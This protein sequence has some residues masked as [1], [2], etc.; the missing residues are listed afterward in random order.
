MN[1]PRCN[2]PLTSTSAPCPAC[3]YW[4]APP[5][6]QRQPVD[7]SH[8]PVR[9]IGFGGAVHNFFAQYAKFSGRATRSE[10]WYAYLFL[11]LVTYIAPSVI[12]LFSTGLSVLFNFLFGLA[13]FI[14]LLAVS[15][16]R[17]HDVSKSGAWYFIG[18]IPVVGTVI[19]LILLCTDSDDDNEYGP[20]KV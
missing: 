15:W 14:P 10:F 6:E 2:T 11:L 8:L 12:G 13:T 20:R 5:P 1:C 3:G 17:L 7:T 4:E 16:R 19:L 18:L 9:K